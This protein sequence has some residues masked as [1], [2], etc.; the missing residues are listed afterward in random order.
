MSAALTGQVPNALTV[1]R[2]VA[3][4]AV[5]LAFVA[6]PRPMADWAALALFLLA[7]LTDWL[8]GHLARR[9]GQA[10]RFGAMLDPIA[11][12][13]MVLIAVTVVL[14]LSG[15]SPWL[16][17]PGT[18]ILFREIAVSGLR[19]YLGPGA[20]LSVTRLAK[21]KTTAQLAA[22]GLLLLSLALQEELYW[23]YRS[24]TPEDYNAALARG[25][26]DWNGTWRLVQAGWIAGLAGM[27]GFWLAAG[28]T[29]WTGWDYFRKAVS[30][31]GEAG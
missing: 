21:W 31:L 17:V 5:A 23:V 12:K 19:E 14:A 25:P 22:I 16:V 11:D 27:I 3:A 6:L 9:W 18:A 13:A 15:F 7:A 10:S 29:L 4:P 26:E 28:L 30:Q 2:L 8:D 1:F 20:V 24:M